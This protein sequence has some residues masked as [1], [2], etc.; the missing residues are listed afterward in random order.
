MAGVINQAIELKLGQIRQE[1]T[2]SLSSP[3]LAE[4]AKKYDVGITTVKKRSAEGNWPA[5]RTAFQTKLAEYT[6]AEEIPQLAKRI[7]TAQ[8]K[9]FDT[10]DTVLDKMQEGF[11]N[12]SLRWDTPSQAIASSE[13]LV[14]VLQ[15]LGAIAVPGAPPSMQ[16]GAGGAKPTGAVSALQAIFNMPSSIP[17]PAP[18]IVT[19]EVTDAETEDVG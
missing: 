3:S 11:A 8:T 18:V 7:S 19:T 13:K 15:Q 1:Y 2:E 17:A 4:L 10:L 6:Q 12:G 14:G 5:G 16:P 9:L